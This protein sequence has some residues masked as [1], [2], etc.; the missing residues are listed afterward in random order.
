[1][2]RPLAWRGALRSASSC[3]SEGRTSSAR[4]T[5][6]IGTAWAV[7]STLVTSSSL[8][9]F[10]VAENVAELRAEFFLLLG[11][12]GDARQMRDIFDINF[13]GSHAQFQVSG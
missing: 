13:S 3:D 1:M 10:D 7:G 12:E 9:F 8:Q 6:T 4:V 11:R 5:L 2:N